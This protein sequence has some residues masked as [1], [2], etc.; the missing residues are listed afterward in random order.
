MHVMKQYEGMEV[1]PH[2]FLISALV[3]GHWPAS[4]T[5]CF[6]PEERGSGTH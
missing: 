2:L 1:Q 4:S 5:S 6:T 3:D